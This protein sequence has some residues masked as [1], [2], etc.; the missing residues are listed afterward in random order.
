MNPYTLFRYLCAVASGMCLMVFLLAVTGPDLVS[1]EPG[2]TRFIE[3]IIGTVLPWLLIP[4]IT[5]SER[6]LVS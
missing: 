6:R 3:S 5:E 4:G 1:T 2:T